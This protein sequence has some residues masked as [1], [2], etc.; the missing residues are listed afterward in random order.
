LKSVQVLGDG[1]ALE[2]VQ[3]PSSAAMPVVVG[4]VGVLFLSYPKQ[5]EVAT[6]TR[7][8]TPAYRVF[9]MVVF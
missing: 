3:L 2:E 8:H 7:Q 5:A 6:A 1:T 4:S 9:F